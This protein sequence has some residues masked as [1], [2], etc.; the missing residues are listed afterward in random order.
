MKKFIFSTAVFAAFFIS[1]HSEVFACSCVP[2]P[3][4]I[5]I[6]QQVK[7]EYDQS[8]NVFV[9][10]VTEVIAKPDDFFVTVKF[11]IERTWSDKEFQK[12][13]AITTGKDDGSC[14]YAF[15]K[16]KKYLV[17]A[18]KDNNKLSTNICTRTSVA[19][20]NKDIAFLNRIKKPKIKSSPK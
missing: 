1:N 12:E 9:G 8:S 10:E 11:K 13:L 4:N 15:E 16:G 3:E 6:E 7:K 5:T 19:K 20:Q 2:S 17:Y 18:F 14:G